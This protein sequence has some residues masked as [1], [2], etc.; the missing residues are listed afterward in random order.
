MRHFENHEL[1]CKCGCEKNNMDDLTMSMVDTAREI[2]GV[3]YNVNSACR[4]IDHNEYVGGS[5]TSSHHFG[6][7]IDVG[8]LDSHTRFRILK[9]LILAGFTRIGIAKNF[10]HFDNDP[11]KSQEVCWLY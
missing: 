2:S 3:A 11:N 4:C 9:G 5:E 8:A 1:Q 7:A 6:F 10:I